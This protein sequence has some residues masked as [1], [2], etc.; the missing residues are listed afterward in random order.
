MHPPPLPARLSDA[1]ALVFTAKN[2]VR[3]WQTGCGVRI[4][5][6]ATTGTETRRLTELGT[7]HDRH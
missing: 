4:R 5:Y 1:L 6:R 7:D 2:T 3:C